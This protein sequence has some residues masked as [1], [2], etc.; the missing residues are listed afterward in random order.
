MKGSVLTTPRPVPGRLLPTAGALLVVGVALAVFLVAGWDVSAWALGA[1]LW[2]GVR[3]VS[4]LLARLR[5]QMTSLA[6]SGML[7][8]ELVFKTVA[9]LAVLVA[10]AASNPHLALGAALVYALAY[11]F[12]L[13]LSL[14]TYF[15]GPAA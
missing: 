7:A 12:E 5:G 15:G 3:A 2:A 1:V 8:F 10:A 14:A 4:L 13:A 9:V 6:S 11:T